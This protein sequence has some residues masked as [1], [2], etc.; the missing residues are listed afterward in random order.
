MTEKSLILKPTS[1]KE[2]LVL[3]E[4]LITSKKLVHAYN[5][6]VDIRSEHKTRKDFYLFQSTR[7]Y[8]KRAKTYLCS[9]KSNTK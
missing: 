8:Q 5:L 9:G 2:S 6:S 1:L 3:F 4:E 7:F